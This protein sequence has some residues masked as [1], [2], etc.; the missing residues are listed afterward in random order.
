MNECINKDIGQ[1][2]DRYLL[3]LLSPEM[4][5]AFERHLLECP[6]CTAEVENFS[7]TSLRLLHSPRIKKEV[8]DIVQGRAESPSVRK[9]H[10]ATTMSRPWWGR[11]IV[12]AAAALFLILLFRPWN[13]IISS[14]NEAIAGENR[15]AVMPLSSDETGEQ[16]LGKVVTS[17]LLTNLSES[18]RLNILTD[19]HIA[20]I[21]QYLNA[22]NDTSTGIG[23]ALQVAEKAGA[24]WV[25]TGNIN[26]ADPD[27]AMN[28]MLINALS[29]DTVI[30]LH[31]A[32][33]AAGDLF[34]LIDKTTDTLKAGILKEHDIRQNAEYSV[35]DITTRS[36][37][38][39]RQYLKGVALY[40]QFYSE[41]AESCFVKALSYD[42]TFAM[43]YYY[44]GRMK[45]QKYLDEALKY[46]SRSSRREQY[47]IR[48]YTLYRKRD[49]NGFFAEMNK[50]LKD[51]P[52]DAGA[53]YWYAQVKNER[54]DKQTTLEYLSRAVEIDPYYKL[55]YNLMTYIYTGLGDYEKAF[56]A[57][58]MY[59]AICPD[60]ANPYDSRGDIYA[61]MGDFDKAIDF[62]LIAVNIK[63][64]FN[65]TYSKLG[66]MYQLVRDFDK[67]WYWDSTG[68][69]NEHDSPFPADYAANMLAAQGKFD[70]AIETLDTGLIQVLNGV[71]EHLSVP[72][73]IQTKALI[74]AEKDPRLAVREM[75]ENLSLTDSLSNSQKTD[76]YCLMSRL[77]AQA[78]S[79]PRAD[80]IL[81]EL[82]TRLDTTI[83]DQYQYYLTA[84]FIELQRRRYDT[85]IADLCHAGKLLSAKDDFDSRY[86]LA[87]AYIET[88]RFNDA[89]L[90]LDRQ[91]KS[92]NFRRIMVPIWNAK[93]HYYLGRAY[94][95]MKKY[96]LA[97]EQYKYFLDIWKNADWKIKEID[98]ARSRL[99]N[100]RL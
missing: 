33:T 34:S 73:I 8:E 91:L 14:K 49:F 71:M 19:Q 88:G 39:Y 30:D 68:W 22:Q 17:L 37:E 28:V 42:S 50:L 99:A 46:I 9:T 77:L 48:A 61:E 84:G 56:W 36:P 5:E 51:F 53:Y 76:Y 12:W 69:A 54:G 38:A 13:I 97:A 41:E 67:A 87:V 31:L 81:K 25:I 23:L 2:L 4:T 1:E 24:K 43:A 64:R 26:R 11:P 60:E 55:A 47:Y 79:F 44:L 72:E 95:G 63:H 32:G 82:E 18:G 35:T 40:D 94:E 7:Q 65:Y 29:G 57:N 16:W 80:S 58:D 6:F 83:S 74:L 78:G 66:V 3:N 52:L 75:E 92:Q 100:L 96:Q 15:V 62:Y 98:D 90:E 21:I 86:L 27:M 20:N 93:M 10:T 85:A 45:G 89:A 70:K 59:T